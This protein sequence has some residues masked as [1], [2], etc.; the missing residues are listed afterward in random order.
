MGD[1][2]GGIRAYIWHNVFIRPEV[3]VYL[4]NN[5]TRVQLRTRWCVTEGRWATVSAGGS[6]WPD[7]RAGLRRDRGRWSVRSYPQSDFPAH[8]QPTG[9]TI[10]GIRRSLH[11]TPPSIFLPCRCANPCDFCRSQGPA[12]TGGLNLPESGRLPNIRSSLSPPPP[13]SKKAPDPV[14][15]HA[16]AN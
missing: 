12:S 3:R 11:E 15:L 8:F 13:P 9:S 16:E 7:D 1:F 5:N 2:G 4:I 14:K 10:G 6:L